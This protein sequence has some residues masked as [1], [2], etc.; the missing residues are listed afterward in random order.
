MFAGWLLV[1]PAEAEA[2]AMWPKCPFVV[3]LGQ[4]NRMGKRLRAK[5]G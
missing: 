2:E 5:V 4:V 1:G 3:E